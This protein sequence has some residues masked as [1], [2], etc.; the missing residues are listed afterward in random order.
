MNDLSTH[1]APDDP[2]QKCPE[3][4]TAA[5]AQARSELDNIARMDGAIERNGAITSAYQSL[6]RDQPNNWWI[7]LAGYVSV[8]GGCAMQ[9]TQAWD[10]QTFGRMLVDPEDALNALG[11][12][13]MTIFESIYPA[14]KF[15]SDCG[16]ERLRECVDSGEIEVNENIMNGLERINQGS[17][18]DGADIIA[19]HEQRDVVQ[20]V[21]ERH[22]HTF[23]DLRSAENW[24]PGDQTSIPVAYECTRD[25]LVPLGDLDIRDPFDRVDY[26]GLLMNRMMEIEGLQ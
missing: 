12:A 21:Y 20:P 13:N 16:Y 11:D 26:Y 15:M 24:V 5:L 18:R 22:A 6:G 23:E 4:C 19:L 25:N 9:R 14:N 1:H 7:R 10:A 2:I 17:L 3:N 8:Q